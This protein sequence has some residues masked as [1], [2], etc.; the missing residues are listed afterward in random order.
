VAEEVLVKEQ[1]TP[2]R[3]TAGDELTKRLRRDRDFG[4]ICSL[5]LYTTEANR[6]KLVVATPVVDNS[7]PIHAY[8][9]IQG[10]VADDWLA[11]WDMHLY[12]ISV[13]RSS[14]SLVTA[15]RSLGHF[16]IQEPPGPTPTTT[17]RVPKNI[18]LTRVQDVFIED[19][20]IYFIA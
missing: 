13:L 14:H 18:S 4:L 19:A 15:L 17:V 3:I 8:Q 1:L 2:D 5:W 7:G 9:L 6:W 11:A 12:N 10:I 16:E 20:Y